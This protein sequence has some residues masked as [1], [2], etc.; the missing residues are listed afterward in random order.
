MPQGFSKKQK[1]FSKKTKQIV[2]GYT[3]ITCQDGSTTVCNSGT[4]GCLNNSPIYCNSER[5]LVGGPISITCSDG[6]TF[7]CNSG[8]R[9]CFNN[10]L[11]YCGSPNPSWSSAIVKSN[12]PVR[13]CRLTDKSFNLTLDLLESNPYFTNLENTWTPSSESYLSFSFAKNNQ[14]TNILGKV[15]GLSRVD[16]RLRFTLTM[17]QINQNSDS[18]IPTRSCLTIDNGV[19]AY[20]TV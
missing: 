15:T 7:K 19:I 1:L 13:L 5:P 20:S 3:T 12:T 14:Y 10:S 11:L 9:G 16:N 18:T 6:S 8:T 4:E 17:A 2:G